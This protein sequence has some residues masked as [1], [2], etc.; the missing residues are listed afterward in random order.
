MPIAKEFLTTLLLLAMDDSYFFHSNHLVEAYKPHLWY[1]SCFRKYSYDIYIYIYV[2]LQ[3]DD[4]DL[5]FGH[6]T[7]SHTRY[8]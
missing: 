2:L 8:V 3:F 1:R 6:R 7:Q 5:N 4:T